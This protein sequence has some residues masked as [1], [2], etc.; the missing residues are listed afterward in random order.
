M[1]EIIFMSHFLI[2]L[3]LHPNAN[4][5]RCKKYKYKWVNTKYISIIFI[6]KKE[7]DKI[8]L[9]SS[10]FRCAT[11][12]VLRLWFW[13]LLTRVLLFS[14]NYSSLLIDIYWKVFTVLQ[15]YFLLKLNF[16]FRYERWVWEETKWEE[17]SCRLVHTHK[18][19]QTYKHTN[20]NHKHT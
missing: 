7:Y 1:Y 13:I 9:D 12:F 3:T 16:I 5:A 20:K 8:L 6:K 11:T 2:S 15:R 17:C 4:N 19:T 10:T 18:H 14:E